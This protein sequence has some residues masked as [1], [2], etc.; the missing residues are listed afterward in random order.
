MD[1]NARPRNY[2]NSAGN[3][4]RPSNESR[5]PPGAPGG[6]P[7]STPSSSRSALSR[8]EKFEDERRRITTSCFSKL[9]TTNQR[10]LHREGYGY[11]NA[12]QSRNPTLPTSA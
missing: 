3:S 9:D 10:T 11:A 1:P 12:V 8:A 7:S 2:Q 5:R 6:P 4:G